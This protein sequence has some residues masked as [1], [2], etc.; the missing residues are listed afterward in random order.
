[1]KK[2]YTKLPLGLQNLVLTLINTYKYYQKYGAIP[3]FNPLKKIIQEL[4]VSKFN[5]DLVVERINRLISYATANVPYY[6][7]NKDLYIPLKTVKDLERIPILKKST[8]KEHNGDFISVEANKYNSYS[9]KTSGSTGTPLYGA[10]KNS[11]LRTRFEMFLTSLKIEGID[12]SR[13]LARFPGA[14]LARTGKVFRR[15]F[16]NGHMLFSIYHLSDAKICEYHK[17]LSHYKIE[18]LEG[19]PSTIVSLVRFLKANKL[20]LPYV[21]HVLTTAEKLL[22]NHRQ[23]IEEFFDTKVFDF[24]GSSEGSVY[25]FSTKEG[26][27]LN[28]NIIGFFECVDE[29]HETVKLN[30]SGRL[31][32]TSFSSSYTPLIRYDIGDYATIISSDRDVIKVKEI[33]G[34]QEEIF[35]TPQGKAF[36]RFSLI[37]KYLPST[38]MESQLILT[39][40]SNKA[41]IEYISVIELSID[42]FEL[43]EEKL[44]SLLEMNFTFEYQ[45]IE[46]FDKSKRGKLSAVKIYT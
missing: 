37:L 40:R 9:F 22:D 23:E 27:Y 39:Q 42:N 12:Y 45:R 15:D 34:R 14:D 7:K 2:I 18:I 24:Y 21:K 28:S 16:I 32:V 13:P 31:I 8:L 17:A 46:K 44:N 20:S 19:Y 26:H 5:D 29:N 41:K 25:M 35:I 6:R 36:G 38:I 1:M 43:F 3:I 4:D 11:E 33:Q 30:E 10:I